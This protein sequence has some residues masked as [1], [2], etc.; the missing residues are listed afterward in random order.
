MTVDLSALARETS[1]ALAAQ[2]PERRVVW[3]VIRSHGGRVWTQAAPDRGA[4]FYFTLP[5]QPGGNRTSG[6]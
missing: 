1:A 4:A 6:S 2:E 3:R 5:D